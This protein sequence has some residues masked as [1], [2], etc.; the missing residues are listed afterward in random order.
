LIPFTHAAELLASILAESLPADKQMERY[1]RAHPR[2][3][4]RERGRIAETVYACLRRRLYLEYLLERDQAPAA[5][6]VAAELLSAEGVSARALRELGWQAGPGGDARAERVAQRAREPL[7]DL[8]LAVR[9]NLPDWLL[10]PLR[11]ELGEAE[12]LQLAAALNRPAPLDLRANTLKCTREAL[13]ARLAGEGYA[14]EPTPYSPL[15]LRRRERAPLFKTGSFR[16][17]WFEVQD[18]GSQLLA[19]L[20][21]PR[22]RE[23]V[24]DF[25]AGAGGKTLALGA[26]MGNTGTLYAFDVSPSRLAR[27][28]PRAARAGLD[29]VRT[30]TIA[31]ERDDRVRRLNGKIDRVLVDAPCSG[32]GTLRRSP[33]LKWRRPD[34]DALGAQQSRILAAAASLVKP[35]GRLVYATCS[36]LRAENDAVVA[37]FLADHPAFTVLPA[38]DILARRGVL[39]TFPDSALRLYPHRHDTDGFYA[40]VMKSSE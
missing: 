28:K 27:L 39:L 14:T 25:C 20:V 38:G 37:A 23:M 18:E 13:A 16:D 21:E 29:T 10:D 9:T 3:G 40:M 34:L 32:S 36:L 26:A 12:T 4:Q 31:H 24:V 7:D 30:V 11:G 33:D 35:G 19:L 17:G 15:G 2:L 1:F 22:R 6:L 5:D 8:P